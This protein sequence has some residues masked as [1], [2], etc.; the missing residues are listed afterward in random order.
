MNEFRIGVIG[1]GTVGAGVV[2]TIMKNASLMAR[3]FG[4]EP[5]IARI[6]DL[7]TKTD[8]GIKLPPGLL[9]SDA[10]QL[11]ADPEI[12]AVVELVGGTTIARKFVSEALK[13]G[14]P[15]VTANKALLAFCGKELF[16][17][18]AANHTEIYFEASVGGGIPCIKALR[19]GLVANQIV[20][21]YGILNG[22]CNYILTR[23]ENENADFESILKAAQEAGYAEA[24][25]STDI[26]GYDTA[27]KA[28]ILASLAYGK[29]FTLD[30]VTVR[31]IRE[32]T[33]TDIEYA[34]E[35]GYRIKLLATIRKSNGKV[36]LCVQPALVSK[37]SLLG[38]VSGVFNALWVDGD[39]VGSTMY[40]GRGAGRAATSSAVVADLMDLA[41]NSL[42]HSQ[43][44]LPAF[45]VY[46]EDLSLATK[47]DILSRYYVR[48]EVANQPGVLGRMA[49]IL[50]N[51]GISIA[52]VTQREPAGTG[53][54]VP[55]LLLTESASQS[56]IESALN[57]IRQDPATAEPP[58]CF[59]IEDLPA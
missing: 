31:G 10:M 57:E 33:L 44:R 29:W 8:R 41:L 32:V 2:E 6:A 12:D 35:L 49:G 59:A 17:L 5:V 51:H 47:D 9:I 1:F 15:V 20:A 30:D 45:P 23:M 11:I 53:A 22:T 40:Y 19:E 27:N 46:D 54:K 37:K 56:D 34:S 3:R 39:I 18:A 4:I 25:P 14:K 58:I 52:S 50:G 43:R 13:R 26:D 28:A 36:Q 42:H 24:N 7:D 48:I 38:G 16:E 55:M 21:M